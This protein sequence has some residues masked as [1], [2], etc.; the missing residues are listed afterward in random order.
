MFYLMDQP[1]GEQFE[2]L[3]RRY[4]DME[5]GAVRAMVRLLRVGSDLLT[6]FE[7][8]LGGYGLSQGRF[9]TLLVLNRAPETPL[10]PSDISARVGVT[11]A[12]MTRLLDGLVRDGLVERGPH[13][14]DRRRLE[15]WLTEQGRG[16]LE[17]I[18][19]DYWRRV[20]GLMDGLSGDE[21]ERLFEL[22]DKVASGIPELTR[23]ENLEAPEVAGAIE[24]GAY[25][26]GDEAGIG[27]LISGIQREE[28]GMSVTLDDQPD[29]ADI[30][31]FYFSGNGGFWTARADG[32]IIGTIALKD[33]GG[34]ES[35]LRKMFVEGGWRGRERGVAARL[36][37]TLLDHAVSR[38]VRRI[39]L[40][41]TP[42]FTAAHRFYAKSGFTEIAKSA[43]PASF[44]IMSVDTRF[45]MI[46]PGEGK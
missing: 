33:I 5:P 35:A 26:P 21:R 6:A 10:A 9:L 29:L 2:D 27:R 22:L 32:R 28:F 42:H 36:L 23:Q 17:D 15:I 34:N 31:G 39:Y 41:T 30:P 40:G 43:L 20:A 25:R 4:R 24:I 11:R 37:R 1:T 8:L 13:A 18:L 16:L 38:S 14:G 45:F 12:T 46:E 19:P 44:P 3:A 7:R